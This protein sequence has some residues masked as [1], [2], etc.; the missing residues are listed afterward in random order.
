MPIS[1]SDVN[2]KA[3]SA[4]VENIIQ[5]SKHPLGG[6]CR[7]W[8]VA[9]L[10]LAADKENYSITFADDSTTE[11][12]G[13]CVIGAKCHFWISCPNGEIIDPTAGQFTENG[14]P[15]P[16]EYLDDVDTKTVSNIPSFWLNAASEYIEHIE[17]SLKHQN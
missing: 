4:V 3:M 5:S 2:V 10:Q 17:N 13:K 15:L 7:E 1:I 12:N 8:C 11:E 16:Y 14:F 6:F 9:I